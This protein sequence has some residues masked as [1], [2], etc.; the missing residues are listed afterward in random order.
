MAEI[1]ACF[2]SYRHPAFAHG[3]EAKYI[4]HVVDAIESHVAVHTRNYKVF[5]DKTRLVPG[6]QY[7]ETLAEELCRSACMVLVYWPSYL[8]SDYC[9]QEVEAMLRV[10][11]RR[12][13]VLGAQLHGCR[14]FIPFILRGRFED[15][16]AALTKGTHYLD[17]RQQASTPNLN[18]GYNRKMIDE[19]DRTARYI[20]SLCDKMESA[21]D[22]LFDRCKEFSFTKDTERLDAGRLP[23]SGAQPFPGRTF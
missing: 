15:L 16:P 6:Y 11:E 8:E 23:A 21:S 13:A 9:R 2:V 20:K 18:I 17:Y 14:L 3:L 19:L 12:Q 22:R 7:D 10:E 5:Y 4:R 1:N